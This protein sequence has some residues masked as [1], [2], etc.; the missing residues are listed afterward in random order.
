M[1]Q[2]VPPKFTQVIYE[3]YRNIVEDTDSTSC[4]TVILVALRNELWAAAKS[5]DTSII[6]V[7]VCVCVSGFIGTSV[8]IAVC[9]C[10]EL[11]SMACG[12]QTST[13]MKYF[14]QTIDMYKWNYSSHTLYAVM[15]RHHRNPQYVGKPHCKS[16][17]VELFGSIQ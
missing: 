6:C 2:Y 9:D 15:Q 1:L 3:S 4:L 10:V 16:W 17:N 8:S 5:D 12:S 14:A 11:T 13:T 7:C